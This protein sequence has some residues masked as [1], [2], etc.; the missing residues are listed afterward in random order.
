M[1]LGALLVDRGVLSHEQ[2]ALAQSEQASSGEGLPRVLARL[3]LVRQTDLLALLGEQFALPVVSL[4]GREADRE[5]L[6]S[7]PAKLVFRHGCA[8]IERR[9]GVLT[10][11]T[12]DPFDLAAIE[13]LRAVTGCPIRVALADEEELREFVREHYGVGGDTL[14]ELSAGLAQDSESVSVAEDG[15]EAAQEASVIRL[16]NDLLIE[17]IT[18]RATDVHIEPYEK[19]LA[20]RY[21]IDGVLLRAKV[22]PTISRFANAIV[23]RLKIMSN[24]N[25][26]EKRLPQDG[27]ITLRHK[28]QEFDLRV[29]VIPMLFGEGVVLRVLSKTAALM[30]L[31][32]LGM[33]AGVLERWDALIGRPHGI[34]LVTGPTGS[35][36]STT[37]YASLNRIVSDEIKAI[38]VEDPVE[39]HVPGVNQ[40][41]VS[42]KVGLDFSAG[43]RAILR[44]DPDVVMIGEIRDKETA[45]TAVQASL[46]G[47]LVFSTL[48]TNDAAGSTTRLLDMGVEPF[49]VASSVE[50]ILAQRLVRR[51]CRTCAAEHIPDSGDLPPGLQLPPGGALVRG[52][53]CRDC[54]E[55]GYRGRVGIYELLRM[56]DNVR[57]LVMHRANATQIAAAS[58]RDGELTLLRHDGFA[59]ALAKVTTIEEVVRATAT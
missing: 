31:D 12:S 35:G 17:A 10:V 30:S 39:Y 5:A 44:H 16:V 40:I 22:P 56:N 14:D 52:A 26:A 34:L 15:I 24:L 20:V 46:T 47:H 45:E 51:V 38:T 11:A 37:L 43:L 6:A 53:G 23:S 54:R 29:S 42:H 19:E 32:D 49:L 3:G 21:R 18:E 9:R 48:H 41:Q 8:P 59:K 58:L 13:E 7:L 25:V 2:L 28:G 33:P 55:T 27:R 50:G 57:E 36:K 4:V 1:S